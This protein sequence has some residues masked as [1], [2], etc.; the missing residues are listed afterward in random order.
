MPISVHDLVAILFAPGSTRRTEMTVR[1]M[2]DG[3]ILLGITEEYIA[4]KLGL[5]WLLE[6]ETPV[7]VHCVVE[8]SLVLLAAPCWT[9]EWLV[10][11][12]RRRFAAGQPTELRLTFESDG[13]HPVFESADDELWVY[14]CRFCPH[15]SSRPAM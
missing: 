13:W 2:C 5:Y 14:E 4:K 3:S 11:Q 7:C 8:Q 6:D 1:V 9:E 15:H 10:E 12:Y